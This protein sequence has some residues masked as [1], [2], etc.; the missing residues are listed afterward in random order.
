MRLPRY[1]FTIRRFMVLTAVL[2]ACMA[3][4]LAADLEGRASRC[5]TPLVSAEGNLCLL[6]TIGYG[7]YGLVRMVVWAIRHPS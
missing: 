5:G 6:A 2:A 7:G 3:Y 1:R 4:L